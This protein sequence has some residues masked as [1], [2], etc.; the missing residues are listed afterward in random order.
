MSIFT[1]TINNGKWMTGT[2]DVEHINVTGSGDNYIIEYDDIFLKLDGELY[3]GGIATFTSNNLS[4]DELF[5]AVVSAYLRG[6]NSN[7]TNYIGDWDIFDDIMSME[8]WQGDIQTKLPVYD[9]YEVKP[10]TLV[11]ATPDYRYYNYYD[12]FLMLDNNNDIVTDVEAFFTNSMCEDI[13]KILKG[14]LECLYKD[15]Y[16]FD[17]IIEDAGGE[18]AF[19][20]MYYN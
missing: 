17:A 1:F 12:E 11:L 7:Y 5:S 14:E 8:E 20:E 9:G 19:I 10:Y 18:E 4:T 15:D 2:F 13:A 16:N 3:E 6:D